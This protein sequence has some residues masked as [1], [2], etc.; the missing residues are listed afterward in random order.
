MTRRNIK[1]LL[2]SALCLAA[3]SDPNPPIPPLNGRFSVSE[4]AQVLF[5]PGNYCRVRNTSGWLFADSQDA[6]YGMKASNDTA[7]LFTWDAI[8]T[9]AAKPLD[10]VWRIL[11][12]GEWEFLLFKRPHAEELTGQATVSGVC[13]LVVLPDEWECPENIV[14]QGFPYD[15]TSNTYSDTEWAELENSGA[16]FLPAAG[17][18]T[19]AGLE[20]V[21]RQGW[22]WAATNTGTQLNKCVCFGEDHVI[23]IPASPSVEIAVRMVQDAL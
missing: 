16:V 13:G 11:S 12:D 3:C 8:R 5:S 10:G 4:E 15:Y 9:Y 14:W 22:Y 7:D 23:E 17:R 20:E 6:V 21:N 1:F 19:G 18:Q 2:L